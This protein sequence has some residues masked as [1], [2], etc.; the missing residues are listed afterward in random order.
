[1][2]HNIYM[3]IAKR[4]GGDVY[5]GVVGPVRTGKSTF[6]KKFMET[7]VIDNIEDEGKR[8]RTIDELPQSADGRTIMTTEPK[9]VPAEAVKIYLDK[10]IINVR[11]I[12]CV[13]YVVDGVT[14]HLENEKPRMIRTPWDDT[15][16]SFQE[17]AVIGTNKV[18]R[19]HCTI[20]VA[21]IADETITNIT[22]EKYSDAESNVIKELKDIGKPFIV[23]LNSIKP[24]TKEVIYLANKLSLKYDTPVL[25]LNIEASTAEDFSRVLNTVL[26]EFPIQTI[27]INLPTWMRAL[28]QENAVITE[29]IDA[30]KSANISILRMKDYENICNAFIDSKILQNDP[31]IEADAGTGKIRIDYKAVDGVFYEVLSKECGQEISDEQS[32]MCHM[33][34]ACNGHNAFEKIKAALDEAYADGYGIVA[35]QMEQLELA[36]PD[37]I[38]KGDQFGVKLKA[39]APS[40]HIVR[41]DVETEISPTIGSAQQSEDLVR[42][43]THEF[44]N[45]KSGI[46]N[47]NLF[48]K[49]LSDLVRDD[50][51]NKI[52]GMPI[53][54][55][56]KIKKTMT[57]VINE[58]RG[59][60]LCILL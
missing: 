1:M 44:E 4:T 41:V 51:S 31:D 59:G 37:L 54:V 58:N 23:I 50:M 33:I 56:R 38:K 32:L 36:Q 8:T 35:P 16:M 27:E 46:W 28:S 60:V 55:R 7:L 20:G 21:I 14:G 18:I 15:E 13:G 34:K 5:I 57:R 10:A 6:I 17:A 22:R 30:L 3:D 24:N 53:D 48:G 49:S 25:P 39:V 9:F 40:I 42:H 12:D 19:D 45:N 26:M 52:K 11:L 2:D 47:A 29:I 43:L